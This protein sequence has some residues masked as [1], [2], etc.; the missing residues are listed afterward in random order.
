MLA[1]RK[2]VTYMAIV[3]YLMPP[4]PKQA[5]NHSS[6]GG[7]EA[8]FK[9]MHT[10]RAHDMQTIPYREIEVHTPTDI[11]IHLVYTHCHDAINSLFTHT[12]ASLCSSI[13]GP[14][15]MV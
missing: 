13:H 15:S 4:A 2:L 9:G 14:N 7:H 11:Y 8:C 10:A 6:Q 5:A 3:P 1:H 12:T